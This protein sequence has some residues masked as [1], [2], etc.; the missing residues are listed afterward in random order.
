[1]STPASQ[2]PLPAYQ[3]RQLF[4]DHVLAEQLPRRP[5]WRALAAAA[6]PVREAVAA[7]YAA[8]VPSDN[9]AQTEHDLIR[10]VWSGWRHGSRRWK[11][12]GARTRP[13]P[14]V[15]PRLTR[16]SPRPARHPPSGAGQCGSFDSQGEAGAEFVARR[17]PAA[18]SR[19]RHHSLLVYLTAV[20]TA[21]QRGH[22]VPAFLPAPAA[23]QAA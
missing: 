12:G 2:L 7:R 6:R 10:P 18:T 11:R 9:E 8:F 15:R 21:A 20:C 4:S 14:R 16:P 17:L 5:E 13:T 3:N 22:P 1:M 23:A 19:Q